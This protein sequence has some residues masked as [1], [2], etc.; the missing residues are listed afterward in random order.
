MKNKKVFGNK[1]K[2]EKSRVNEGKYFIWI[3]LFCYV[4]PIKFTTLI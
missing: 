2:Y 4:M 3:K 1:P